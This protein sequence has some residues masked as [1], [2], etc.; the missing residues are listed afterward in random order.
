MRNEYFRYVSQE[1]VHLADSR[2]LPGVKSGV[3]LSDETN[4]PHG[5]GLFEP[6]TDEDVYSD[7]LS[8]NDNELVQTLPPGVWEDNQGNASSDAAIAGVVI[9]AGLIGIGIYG[10]YRHIK[11]K[12]E[13]AR[14]EEE[15][16][17]AKERQQEETIRQMQAQYQATID[18]LNN[19]IDELMAREKK[20]MPKDEECVDR[21]KV[22]PIATLPRRNKNSFPACVRQKL[23][24]L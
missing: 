21:N 13:Q 17:F 12:K 19:R 1:G 6:V 8:G 15:R 2:V 10:L 5:A 16:R 3:A 18:Q 9:G 24:E 14:I 4:Q 11:N 22:I 7:F 23:S 20:S